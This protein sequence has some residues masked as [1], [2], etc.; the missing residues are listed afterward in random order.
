M[1]IMSHEFDTLLASRKLTLKFIKDFDHEQLNLIPKGFKNN[2]IWNL[3]HLIVTQQLLWYSLSG[4]EM[5]INSEMVNKYRKGS[6]PSTLVEANEIQE[7]IELLSSLPEK[8]IAD[9]KKGLF[10]TYQA[11]TT[12]F[13]VTLRSIEDAIKFNNFHEGLHVGTIMALRKL[14]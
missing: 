14:V 4:K 9:Y 3:G 10:Q 5:L 11:Y 12:S 8:S 13:D 1:V 6:Q 2:M 7:I